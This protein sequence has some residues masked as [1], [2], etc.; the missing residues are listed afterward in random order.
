MAHHLAELI[1]AAETGEGQARR[2]AEDRA[3]ELVLRLWKNRSVLPGGAD[4]MSAYRDATRVLATMLPSADPWRRFQR[5]SSTERLLHDMLGAMAH[6]VM[7]GLLLTHG[8]DPREIQDAEWDALSDEERSLVLILDTWREFVVTPTPNRIELEGLYRMLI[9]G[10]GGRGKEQAAEV[11]EGETDPVEIERAAVLSHVEAFQ[12]RLD[13]LVAHW[14]ET[15][16]KGKEP[17]DVEED[18]D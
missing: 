10:E 14:R 11:E 13:E 4:P 5:G 3:V 15:Q 2:E 16:A 1:D 17:E 9:D 7:S 18:E 6:L 12:A 8:P